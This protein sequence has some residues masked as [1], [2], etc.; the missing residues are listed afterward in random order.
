MSKFND[1][2]A[3]C[4]ALNQA[5]QAENFFKQHPA[6]IDDQA[7]AFVSKFSSNNGLEAH[8]V[9]AS[10]WWFEAADHGMYDD[11]EIELYP[12]IKHAIEELHPSD[13]NKGIK[14]VAVN[15]ENAKITKHV[16]L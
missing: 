13:K 12:L 6:D 4:D 3:I 16:N 9:S 5:A 14:F 11:G 15:V 2:E 7:N 1:V 8:T 10:R